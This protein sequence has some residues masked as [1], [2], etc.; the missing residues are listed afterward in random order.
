MPLSAT[1]KAETIGAAIEDW[2]PAKM[3]RHCSTCSNARVYGQSEWP[4]VRCATGHG[5]CDLWRL[6]RPLHP[7]GI[8]QARL[9]SDYAS[10]G[11]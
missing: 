5:Y 1:D 3:G 11:D 8:K 2:D 6:I 4:S 7:M 10:S 9:C